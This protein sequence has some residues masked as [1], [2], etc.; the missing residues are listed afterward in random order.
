M[1]AQAVDAIMAIY[2]HHGTKAQQAPEK[3][4]IH[5][6]RPAAMVKTYLTIP[7]TEQSGPQTHD[8]YVDVYFDKDGRCVGK[9][10]RGS[11]E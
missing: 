6:K 1:S 10:M 4:P 8:E 7:S 2:L 11:S 9:R 3:A 5:L